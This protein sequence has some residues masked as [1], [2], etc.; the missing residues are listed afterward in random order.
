MMKALI[1]KA[2]GIVPYIDAY[3][4]FCRVKYEWANDI[5]FNEIYDIALE[6]TKTQD[7]LPHRMRSYTLLQFLKHAPEGEIAEC[8][9]FRGMTAF[10]LYKATGRPIHLFD[11]FEGLSEKT[12]EDCAVGGKGTISCSL[13]AV[14]ESLVGG[15]FRY[16]KGWI[17]DE[18][19]KVKDLQFSFVHIDVDIYQPTCD[20]LDF[21]YPRMMKGGVI[22]IDDYGFRDWPGAKKAVEEMAE[23]HGFKV[24]SLTTGQGVVIKN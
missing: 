15:N 16:Y 18:F 5:D 20:S 3:A 21:F 24:L 9:V 4:E 12:A 8:G 13:E 22:V 23:K 19:H 7:F 6:V 14:K 10:E 11:S 1:K 17:P 2:L